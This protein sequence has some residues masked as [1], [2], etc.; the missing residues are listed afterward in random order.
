MRRVITAAVAVLMACGGV[1]AEVP[2]K[3]DVPKYIKQLK[4][5]ASAKVRAEAAE[6][7]GHRGAIRQAD[8]KDAIEPLLS[9]LKN[10]RDPNVRKAAAEALGRI[11]PDKEVVVK[12]LLAA[13]EDKAIQVRIGAANGLGMLGPDAREAVPALRKLFQR[14]KSAQLQ[15]QLARAAGMALR[16]IGGKFK[17]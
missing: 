12:P 14:D 3:K 1:R 8:V 7:L 2:K 17:K 10:D 6:A 15:G 13:L 16:S 11:G 5:A 9:A 4:S